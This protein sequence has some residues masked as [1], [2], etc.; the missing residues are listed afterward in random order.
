[1]HTVIEARFTKSASFAAD[2]ESHLKS[3][4]GSTA[5]CCSILKALDYSYIPLQ[6]TP[7]PQGP[8]L[9]HVS[10]C[11]SLSERLDLINVVFQLNRLARIGNELVSDYS[12]VRVCLHLRDYLPILHGS[13]CDGRME[14]KYMIPASAKSAKFSATMIAAYA[15]RR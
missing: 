12:S 7:S 6:A 9:R 10:M 8:L 1:M 4:R 3:S 13:P 2:T 15:C 11:Q 5:G 14:V